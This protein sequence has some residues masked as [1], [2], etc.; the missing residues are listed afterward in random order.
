M[1][2]LPTLLSPTFEKILKN[3]NFP[4]ASAAANAE[5]LQSLQEMHDVHIG[6]SRPLPIP[7][8]F[9]LDPKGRVSVIYK[10]KQQCRERLRVFLKVII[11]F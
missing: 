4:F 11:L 10:G 5:V 2:I 3:M 8:A 1:R 9:L 6:L 7:S